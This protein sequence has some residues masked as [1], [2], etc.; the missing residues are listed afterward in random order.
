MTAHQLEAYSLTC[1]QKVIKFEQN[2]VPTVLYFAIPM[3]ALLR[4]V[5][6]LYHDARFQGL[7]LFPCAGLCFYK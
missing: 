4:V 5:F 3:T 2:I 7:L 6:F 1:A